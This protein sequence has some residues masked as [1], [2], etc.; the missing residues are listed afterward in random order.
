MSSGVE[1]HDV[2][3]GSTDAEAEVRDGPDAVR[4]ALARV[5][6]S[7]EFLASPQLSAFLRYVV[8]KTL[9]GREDR[10]KGY[11]IAVEA[12]GRDPSFDPQADPIVRVEATRLRRA[13]AAYY[14]RDGAADPLVIDMPRGSYVPTFLA[15]TE[16]GEG[17]P[18]DASE[19]VGGVV[20]AGRDS[21]VAA[22]PAARRRGWATLTALA[23]SLVAVVLAGLA[24]WVRPDRVGDEVRGARLVDP[25]QQVLPR[26]Y[27]DS[28]GEGVTESSIDPR[29]FADEVKNALGLFDE[30]KVTTAEGEPRDYV[31]TGRMRS[32]PTEVSLTVRLVEDRTGEIVWSGY[33][34]EIFGRQTAGRVKGQLLR[35]V[36]T[37]IAQPYGVVQSHALSR[38]VAGPEA[39]A[40]LAYGQHYTCLLKA[41]AYW[42]VYSREAHRDARDCLEGVLATTPG[43]A[44]GHA[45]LTFL[46]LDE[47]R[48]G[49]NARPDA[50]PP[51]DRALG[52]ARRAVSLA[53]ESPRCRQALI[54]AHFVRGEFAPLPELIDQALARNP[55][56]TDLAADMGAKLVIMGE[57]DK[58]R[59]LL[60]EAVA[61]HPSPAPWQ[62]FFLFLADWLDGDVR[63]AARHAVR[64]DA[65]DY[66]LGVVAKLLSAKALGS[67]EEAAAMSDQ[68]TVVNPAFTADP[69]R[70]LMRNLPNRAVVERLVA[71]L[72]SAR[73]ALSRP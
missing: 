66:S 6:A 65:P 55:F 30:V 57:R 19:P 72:T 12:L 15:K 70:F 62:H 63:S 39:T 44:E 11:T 42:R 59:R 23:L 36:S 3:D 54:G 73:M 61:F 43:F 25:F 1:E 28:F 7:P 58:G 9:E 51:L 40:A 2:A 33:Y 37:A 49:F 60:E 22:A 20:V 71:D 18:V 53:P 46:T 29:D 69:T 10:I 14:G 56:D 52:H 45:A 35:Q 27:V 48:F 47:F 32:D 13:L 68:L 26:I 24:L 41:F 17:A 64:I 21:G 34:R 16:G 50:A 67:V 38:L 31:L 8:E 5:L 4:A